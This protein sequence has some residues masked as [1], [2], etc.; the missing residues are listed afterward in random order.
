[1]YLEVGRDPLV[2]VMAED[3][4]LARR[5][6]LTARRL[7]ATPF[8]ETSIVQDPV[9]ADYWYLRTWRGPDAPSVASR[10]ATVEEWLGEVALG[11][12]VNL[13]PEGMVEE[14][15]KQGLAFVPVADLEPS[16]V[17]VAWAPERESGAVRRFVD[18][19]RKACAPA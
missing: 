5:P 11:R 2:A 3:H 19:A 12:G 17:V 6:V 1:M 10:A 13:V 7:A 4:P 18:L 8:L 16:P 15:R 14:Y 9:F